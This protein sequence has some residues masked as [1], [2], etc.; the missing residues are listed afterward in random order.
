M[1][2]SDVKGAI[3]TY[4]TLQKQC[5]LQEQ[6]NDL[7]VIITLGNLAIISQELFNST[8][9]INWLIEKIRFTYN[10]GMLT[11]RISS[12]DAFEFF[13]TSYRTSNGVFG[14]IS[15]NNKQDSK[16]LID[17]ARQ[18]YETCMRQIELLEQ[19]DTS[20]PYKP[21]F[22]AGDMAAKIYHLDERKTAWF[23]RSYKKK[24]IAARIAETIDPQEAFN[25]YFNIA[26]ETFYHFRPWNAAW[27]D[28]SA[29]LAQKGLDFLKYVQTSTKIEK[30]EF[31]IQLTKIYTMCTKKNKNKT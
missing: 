17:I 11:R 24:V 18:G 26:K 25:I 13:Q 15:Q 14:I 20:E 22:N 30:E 6:R 28:E 21:Y 19:F 4:Q 2:C 7:Q 23:K 12:K 5:L 8:K 1:N 29:Q 10:A 31:E 27:K 9:E 16:S 3:K